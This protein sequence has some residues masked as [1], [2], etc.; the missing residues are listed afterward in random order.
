MLP[1]TEIWM[2]TD[3]FPLETMDNKDNKEVVIIKVISVKKE[4]ERH[5]RIVWN[6][7]NRFTT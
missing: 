2:R 3:M 7:R 1:G 6:G 4:E 5:I